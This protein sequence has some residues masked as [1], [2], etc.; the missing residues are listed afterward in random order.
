MVRHMWRV[1][2]DLQL[3]RLLHASVTAAAA[4]TEAGRGGARAYWRPY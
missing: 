4:G 3:T 1:G 2:A